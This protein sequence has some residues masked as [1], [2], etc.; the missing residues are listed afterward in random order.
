[1]LGVAKLLNT[2]L[3]IHPFVPPAL[4]SADGHSYAAAPN[5][6]STHD[7]DVRQGTM[8]ADTAY[9]AQAGTAQQHEGANSSEETEAG[10][11]HSVTS[12]HS[13]AVESLPT[14]SATVWRD[15]KTTAMRAFATLEWLYSAVFP[16]DRLTEGPDDE[17]A[18]AVSNELLQLLHALLAGHLMDTQLDLTEL[19]EIGLC[20]VLTALQLKHKHSTELGLLTLQRLAMDQRLVTQWDKEA[21]ADDWALQREQLACVQIYDMLG[22][23]HICSLPHTL[24]MQHAVE[25]VL[26]TGRG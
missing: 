13:G 23:L 14:P 15:I 22:E 26:T 9:T 8:L 2:L 12:T 18:Q 20:P 11:Q 4:S 3:G 17:Q 1:M 6:G 7:A 24:C 25:G 5:N 10:Q 19:F 21:D 16:R